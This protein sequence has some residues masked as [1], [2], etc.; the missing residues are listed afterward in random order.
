[1]LS[2]VR[3]K[4]VFQGS[5]CAPDVM[6][7]AVLDVPRNR[8]R[9]VTMGVSACSTRTWYCVL[10][11]FFNPRSCPTVSGESSEDSPHRYKAGVSRC[12]WIARYYRDWAKFSKLFFEK[13]V[14][15]YPNSRTVLPGTAFTRCALS[16]RERIRAHRE[17]SWKNYTVNF[18]FSG[19]GS[20]RSKN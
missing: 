18:L 5:Q 10:T 4:H 7:L 20:H 13:R 1:M 11:I 19:S 15:F 16:I 17:D 8:A 3:A 2:I 14:D 6:S 9:M 12:E